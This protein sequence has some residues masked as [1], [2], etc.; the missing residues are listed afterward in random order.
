MN[1]STIRKIYRQK[2]LELTTQDVKLFSQEIANNF[3]QNLLPTIANFSSKKLAFYVAANNE[4]DPIFIMRH[5]QNLGNNISLPIITS[6][7][8]ILDFKTYRI[9]DNLYNNDLYPQI[10]EP[11]GSSQNVTPDIIFVPL[12]AF[13]KY[14]NRIGMGGGFYDTTINNY[15]KNNGHQIFV[16]LGYNWQ[17]STSIDVENSDEILDIIISQNNIFLR[18]Q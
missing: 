14:C 18:N 5:C 13:D 7:H 9:G 16:G 17:Q 3:I 8:L 2:R 12:V 15:K 4:V 6:G 11:N 1:K 10:L